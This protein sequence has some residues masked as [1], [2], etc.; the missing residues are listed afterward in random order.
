MMKTSSIIPNT[1]MS[2]NLHE[3]IQPIFFDHLCILLH[4]AITTTM[5]STKLNTF[6]FFFLFW[7]SITAQLA[8]NWSH[9]A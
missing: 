2:M 6:F 4:S 3:Y 8:M 1:F 5:I 7:Q 9:K